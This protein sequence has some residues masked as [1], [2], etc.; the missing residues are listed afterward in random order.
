MRFGKLSAKTAVAL[1]LVTVLI[2]VAFIVGCNTVRPVSLGLSDMTI[3]FDY[4]E[5]FS[6][7]ELKVTV[8]YS[9]GSS[10]EADRTEYIVDSSDYDKTV[11]GTY[12]ITVKLKGSKISESYN[13]KV[14]EAEELWSYDGALKI[15]CIGNSFSVDMAEYAYR[16][17]ESLGVENIYI[18]NLYIGGCTLDTHADNARKNSAAYTYYKNTDGNWT[19]QNNFRMGDA[20]SSQNWD[21]VTLQQASG[22]S[23]IESTYGELNYLVDYVK[24]HLPENSR[25]KLVWHMTWAYQGDSN[26]SEF[27]KY[28]SSQ[29][30]MYEMI[31]SSVRNKVLPIR[32]FN[33]VIPS[34]TAIQNARTSFCGDSFTRDGYHLSLD[35]GR[36]IAGLTMISK[37]TKLSVSNI[38][39]APAGVDG[40]VKAIAIEC[41]E[42][43]I[44]TPFSI[45]P[46]E[47][48]EYPAPSEEN[49]TRLDI[50]LTQGF[51]DSTNTQYYNVLRVNDLL[52]DKFFGTKRFTKEE[53][54]VGSIIIIESGWQYRPEGWI[55]DE[56]QSSRPS[57]VTIT[58]LEVTENWWGDY[59]LRAFNIAKSG[60]PVIKDLT[61]EAKAAFKIYVP[62]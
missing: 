40:A 61:E 29:S 19:Q 58:R 44:K 50:E 49:Y 37:L 1:C 14:H 3:D 35:A 54:P 24:E 55:K 52:T 28:E 23:G 47:Y 46:S 33:G 7:D 39:Y 12:E 43:A 4:G 38:E 53:I 21:F 15:L 30:K 27:P 8:S 26:H 36:Y 5:D 57:N 31:V 60:T 18:G 11:S 16:I 41:A 25:A 51:W 20:I 34:G 13:V 59:S 56:R 2:W 6:F 10:S 22:S 42:N 9:D 45:T 17:A 32:D 48:A 62:K